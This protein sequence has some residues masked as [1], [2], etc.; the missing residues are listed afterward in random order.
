MLITSLKEHPEFKSDVA[1]CFHTQWG[2]YYPERSLQDWQESLNQKIIYIALEN[3]KL[4]GMVGLKK[5]DSPPFDSNQRLELAALYTKP[6]CRNRGIGAG[7]I[8]Y[9]MQQAKQL[10]HDELFLFTHGSGDLYKK[11]GWELFSEI[12][13]RNK[14]AYLFR[15][16]T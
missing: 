10:G 1:A 16:K 3:K 8:H 14:Q 2:P 11:L 9:A 12:T 15:K 5:T 4:L 13:Y 6:A 7:L